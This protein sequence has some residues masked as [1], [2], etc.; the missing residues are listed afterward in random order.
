MH[1]AEI[2][3]LDSGGYET[4]SYYDFAEVKKKNNKILEWDEKLHLKVLGKW[5]NDF[6]AIIINYD[7]YQRR[8][9]LEKQINKANELFKMFPDQLNDFLIKPEKDEFIDIQK[10]LN[11]I[12]LLKE[13]KIIGITEKELGESILD[14]MQ[15]I[16]K[17]RKALDIV[18]ISSPIHIFGCLDPI[19][20]ILYYCAGAEIFDGLTW[21]RYS[22]YNCLTIYTNNF[23]IVNS[24]Y[25]IGTLDEVVKSNSKK[26]NLQILARLKQKMIDFSKTKNFEV[27]RNI[28]FP[29]MVEILNDTYNTFKIKEE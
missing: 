20:C 21:L 22:Y 8:I 16:S 27:F 4:A 3:F 12:Y 29:N 25:N 14:R 15:K 6:Y 1:F 23:N 5:Q 10:I 28:G 2:T 19:S 17:I 7:H 24:N 26:N 9:K 18:G 11:S 13:F